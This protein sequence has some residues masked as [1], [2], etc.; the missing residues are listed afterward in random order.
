[1]RKET[2]SGS[3]ER[4][5]HP[6]RAWAVVIDVA[7]LERGVAFWGGLLGLSEIARFDQYV[8]FTDIVEGMRLVLQET[9]TPKEAKNRVHLDITW[10]TPEEIIRWV[11]ENGGSLLTE[12]EEPAYSLVVMADPDGNELCINRRGSNL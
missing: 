5:D 9:D 12:V 2:L 4:F 7:D 1:M 11:T 10:E 3:S 6:A 8:V